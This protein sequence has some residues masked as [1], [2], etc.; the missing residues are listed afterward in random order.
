LSLVY[1][2]RERNTLKKAFVSCAFKK[3]SKG[4]KKIVSII[5]NYLVYCKRNFT[6]L[7]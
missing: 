3:K 4:K 6:T 7:C 2:Y 1:I 5:G